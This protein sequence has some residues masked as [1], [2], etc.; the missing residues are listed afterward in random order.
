MAL[1]WYARDATGMP[2]LKYLAYYQVVEYYFHTYAQADARR[3]IQGFIKNSVFRADRDADIGR[4][5]ALKKGTGPGFG[6][7]RSQLRATF[8]EC[9][10]PT[11]LR[12]FLTESEDREEFFSKKTEGLT[13]KKLPIRNLD[14][15]LRNEVADRI[16]EIRCKFVHTKGGP[17]DQGLLL[18][19]RRAVPHC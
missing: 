5:L 12:E 8:L 1:Y 10:D 2:L 13:D 9:L 11:S 16:Y 17:G 15:D 19:K 7:E 18:H 3:K 6:D 14:A 4:I